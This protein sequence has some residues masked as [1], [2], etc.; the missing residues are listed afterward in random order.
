MQ[1]LQFQP[2]SS[3]AIVPSTDSPHSAIVTHVTG[4]SAV[5][6]PCDVTLG[7]VPPVTAIPVAYTG[8]T[9]GITASLPA[10]TTTLTPIYSGDDYLH[11]ALTMSVTQKCVGGNCSPAC[12]AEVQGSSL[13][14]FLLGP[15][16]S[17]S[18]NSDLSTTAF[19]DFG[20]FTAEFMDYQPLP[21]ETPSLTAGGARV[22]APPGSVIYPAAL[23][24][25]FELKL[26]GASYSSL[27]VRMRRVYSDISDGDL[28]RARML[29]YGDDGGI[30]DI[31]TAQTR[32]YIEGVTHHNSIF[33]VAVPLGVFDKSGP[34]VSLTV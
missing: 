16:V 33:A 5:G 4:I 20:D 13:L 34:V 17:I 14:G 32:D 6:E 21:G 30:T 2:V 8:T 31:T 10:A 25:G 28:P 27:K 3:V 18:R 7:A 1:L 26:S 19:Y 11:G 24:L 22:Q 9:S 23:E 29:Q 15:K 12:N